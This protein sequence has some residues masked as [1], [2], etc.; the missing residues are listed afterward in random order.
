MKIWFPSRANTDNKFRFV[1]L[2]YWYVYIS[3]NLYI[4]VISFIPMNCLSNQ[5]ATTVLSIFAINAI[6]QHFCFCKVCTTKGRSYFLLIGV[7]SRQQWDSR[8]FFLIYLSRTWSSV[9]EGFTHRWI[10][11]AFQVGFYVVL[12]K[13][14][15]HNT[16]PVF[17]CLYLHAGW[18]NDFSYFFSVS[19][20]CGVK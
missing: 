6:S 14:L 13:G 7:L 9:W 8:E 10:D 19:A 12:C 17:L 18:P 3:L 16:D 4:Y 11:D 2:I 5:N 20:M 15:S 1:L